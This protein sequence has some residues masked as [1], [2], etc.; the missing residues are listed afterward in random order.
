MRSGGNVRALTLEYHDVVVG[1]DYDST[2]F[3]GA[4]PASYKLTLAHFEEH[5]AAIATRGLRAG[6]VTDWLAQPRGPRPLFLTFDD[7]GSSAHGCIADALE[8]HGW[9][10]HFFVTAGKIGAPTFLSAADMRDLHARGHVIGS[11]SWSH[12]KMMGAL[13]REQVAQE[14]HRS[15]A[16]IQD[17]LGAPCATA[18]VPGGFYRPYLASEAAVAGIRALF[19]SNP[20]TLCAQV[21]D[22]HV[23]G[24]YTLRQWSNSGT[25][26]EIAAGAILP[27]VSQWMLYTTLTAMRSL[28]GDNY[29]RLRQK[30]WAG[31]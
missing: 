5:L 31:R 15:V 7:G 30:F 8:R 3:A 13:P 29:T 25:A 9:R 16:A 4:G 21:G 14:W 27:R 1:D 28:L 6:R 26:A 20:S 18:S 2:G 11:H 12:P 23:L 17:A 24:R 22:C 19:T 10:G